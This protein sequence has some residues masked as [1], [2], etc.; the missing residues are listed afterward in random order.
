MQHIIVIKELGKKASTF[1]L[2]WQEIGNLSTNYSCSRQLFYLFNKLTFHVNHLG[3]MI[4]M[5]CQYLFSLKNKKK[6]KNRKSSAANF[7]WHFKG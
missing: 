3:Q 1:M 5:K 7:A 4:H 2:S 6:K